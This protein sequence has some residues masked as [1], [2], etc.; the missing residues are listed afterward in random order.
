[1]VTLSIKMVNLANSIIQNIWLTSSL[2][3][4]FFESDFFGPTKYSEQQ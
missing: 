4:F 2:L 3:F 1:M